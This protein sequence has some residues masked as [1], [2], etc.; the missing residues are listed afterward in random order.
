MRGACRIGVGTGMVFAVFSAALADDLPPSLP[1]KAPVPYV[2]TAYDW[3][4]WYV[5]AHGGVIKGASN[6][7]AQPGAG[8][9]DLNG[10]F[11][12][13]FNL[14]FMAGDG[15]VF[16]WPPTVHGYD[17]S[18]SLVLWLPGC[19]QRVPPAPA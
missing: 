17:F 16:Y 15:C 6:W 11:N 7:T 12:L 19:C 9:P 8:A 18:S 10:S 5:G 14:D 1:V 2:A 13:P 4:G 3:N